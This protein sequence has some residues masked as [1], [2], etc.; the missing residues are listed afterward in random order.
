MDLGKE[1]PGA[2]V[3][4]LWP[5]KSLPLSALE[6]ENRLYEA[7][8]RQALT[9]FEAENKDIID[10]RRAVVGRC[11][12]LKE[13][14]EETLR[15]LESL[16]REEAE[17]I[18]TL[19]RIDR[20]IIDIE[21]SYADER[22]EVAAAKSKKARNEK[23]LSQ[24]E[25]GLISVSQIHEAQRHRLELSRK[26]LDEVSAERD[27]KIE[28]IRRDIAATTGPVRPGENGITNE[29]GSA[30]EQF[31]IRRM[32]DSKEIE[33]IEKAY[34]SLEADYERE[35]RTAREYSA[36]LATIRRELAER[37]KLITLLEAELSGVEEAKALA[38]KDGADADGT[39]RIRC[40]PAV[41]AGDFQQAEEM[42]VRQLQAKVELDRV[43]QAVAE[44]QQEA[45]ISQ[46]DQDI[47]EKERERKSDALERK[48]TEI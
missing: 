14:I 16:Q 45:N 43:R 5:I 42:K 3:T 26:S 40:D 25:Q 37:R 36:A 20:K 8:E 27:T 1:C 7:V 18:N 13:E 19:S 22:K 39:V 48:W 46:R 29:N 12:H 33:K 21:A 31:W 10:E 38:I 15:R 9:K 4:N 11:L 35:G 30:F 41:P 24:I 23:K 47:S 2:A 17:E 28:Q 32:N 6:N 34:Q 44:G